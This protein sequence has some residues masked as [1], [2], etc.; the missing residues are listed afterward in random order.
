MSL[1][2]SF[3]TLSERLRLAHDELEELHRTTIDKPPKGDVVLVDLFGDAA[4]DLLG[5][6]AE[7]SVAASEG[8]QASGYPLD[9]DRVRQSLKTCQEAFFLASEKLSS[10]LL[11]YDRIEE[12][13]SFGRERGGG[14]LRWAT[15]VK[16]AVESC[17]GPFIEANRALFSCW[18]ELN[19]RIGTTSVSVK[20][21]NVGQQI[22]VP[23]SEFAREGVP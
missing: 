1:A 21:T 3:K 6:V 20:T 9:L 19:E 12:L 8:A 7:A 23:A 22:T 15:N 10:D 17:R 13:M 16:V 14:W 11:S 2:E 4:D 5:W 18:Q